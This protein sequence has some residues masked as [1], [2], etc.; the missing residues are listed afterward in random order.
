M[1]SYKAANVIDLVE[2]GYYSEMINSGIVHNIA[3]YYYHLGKYIEHFYQT[4]R[5]CENESIESY[6]VLI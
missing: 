6:Q 5:L 4:A 2:A 1:H 3:D